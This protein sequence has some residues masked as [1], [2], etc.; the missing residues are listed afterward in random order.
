MNEVLEEKVKQLLTEA[1]QEVS[2][3]IV[4]PHAGCMKSTFTW[5][6]DDFNALL[7]DFDDF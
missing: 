1:R 2:D 6:S 7:E 5:M 4:K 3:Y